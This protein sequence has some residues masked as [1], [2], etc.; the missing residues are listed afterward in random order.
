MRYK[1][2]A[3]ICFLLFF[4]NFVK[5]SLDDY[6]YPFSSPSFSEFGTLG[7]IRMPSARFYEAGTI[8]FN[9]TS[10][11]PYTRGSIV[12]YPFDWFEASYQYTD[13]NNALYSNVESF[14]GNQ[15]YKDKGFDVK[16]RLLNETTFLPSL[17][18]GIRDIAGTGT[19]AAE[20]LVA[21]KLI[22]IELPFSKNNHR[23]QMDFT[24]GIG[25]GDLS[26]NK[27]S[28]PLIDLDNSFN[29]RT[30]I[31]DTLGGEFS[32]GRYFSGPIGL[33]GG[34][35]IPLPN[36]NGLRLKIEYDATDYE[37][38]GFAFG[39]KSFRFAF[40]PVKQSQSRIN[41]GLTYPV[42]NFIQL[43]G[44]FTKGNTF[45]IGFSMQAGFGPKDPIVK[46]NDP[47]KPVE[48]AEVYKE[49]ITDGDEKYL[50]NAAITFL[51][52]RDILLQKADRTDEKLTILYGQNKHMS[53]ARATGRIAR[54]LDEISP[55][56]IEKFEI[57]NINAGMLMHSIEVDRASFKK[58]KKDK[59]Y[60]LPVKDI[61]VK[62]RKFN[63]DDYKFNPKA[64]FPN[65]FYS[66]EPDLR[67]QIG[68]PDGFYF[69]DLRVALNSEIQFSNNLMLV[70]NASAGIYNNFDE[71]KLASD[72][73]LPHVRTDV[74][75]YLRA[76]E[77]F[78]IKRF[79]LNYFFKPSPNVY[80]KTSL[81]LLEEMFG[82]VGGEILYRPMH[83]PYA[84]GA[85]IWS[86]RQRDFDMQF[87]FRD[88][89]TESGHINFF[90]KLPTVQ[91]ITFQ[92]KG[93]R[94][95][96]GDSGINF[97]ISRRFKSGL[98][99]G[100]F[101]AKTDISKEEFGEGSFDKG[102]YFTIPIEAFF[103]NYDRTLA[104]WGLRPLTRDGA[105]YVLH[106]H[107]LYGITEQGHGY[108]I[109]RDWDDLYD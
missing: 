96:A 80:T 63:K 49:V 2:Y 102:F 6:I 39:R 62:A 21:S 11:D 99:M 86:L 105:A 47:Y 35:E 29:E 95:L 64:T 19:F 43:F 56:Y 92:M 93:G 25:W 77:R 18:I 68:G 57:Q 41:V 97:E 36:L 50:Y 106:S 81:G 44:G 78:A 42:N 71:L 107:N 91:D 82:G 54:V 87:S 1:H 61:V 37:E 17:A 75:Q 22:D 30:I 53:H 10:H 60:N 32:P 90:Y 20:Y 101:F 65:I 33:F 103:S 66:F 79:Q 13:V 74:V 59:I 104:S 76:T 58:Y 7:L 109:S 28:N 72:S 67:S 40:E 27:F 12:A 52:D 48:G 45:S 14:S 98:R 108:T 70:T 38:E 100:A 31:K 26:Y 73:I 88:Y 34:V 16:F 5:P 51:K 69:G 8:A 55:D 94:F 85:E 89:E 84:I 23:S 46:K 83:K 3:Y 15:T 9:W 24:L 4:S